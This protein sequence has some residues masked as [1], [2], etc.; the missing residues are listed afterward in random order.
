MSRPRP[1]ETHQKVSRP[2]LRPRVSLLTDPTR[3]RSQMLSRVIHTDFGMEEDKGLIV[4]VG[5][6]GNISWRTPSQNWVIESTFFV[7]QGLLVKWFSI[8]CLSSVWDNF[9]KFYTNNERLNWSVPHLTI[10]KSFKIIK[11][12]TRLLMSYSN[13][14]KLFKK[15]KKSLQN[16]LKLFWTRFIW[17]CPPFKQIRSLW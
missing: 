5:V 8:I 11:I 15:I 1:T 4:G 9:Y 16:C 12:G 17:K 6:I 7:E 13:F 14:F 10:L 3:L 2:R